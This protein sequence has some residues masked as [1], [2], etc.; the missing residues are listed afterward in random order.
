[1][2]ETSY[3]LNYVN[4][5]IWNIFIYKSYFLKKLDLEK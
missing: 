1:M 5:F 2:I 3:R 4:Y